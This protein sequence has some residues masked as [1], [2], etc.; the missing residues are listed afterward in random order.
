MGVAI[1]CG[2]K[3]FSCGYKRWNDFRIGVIQATIQYIETVLKPTEQINENKC[4]LNQ[5]L[6][7][8]ELV[9][10]EKADENF[11][12]FVFLMQTSK[13]QD[14][15]HIQDAFIHFGLGGLFV[16]CYKTDCDGYY[17][18]GNSVDIC[19]LFKKIHGCMDKFCPSWK[20][21]RSVFREGVKKRELVMV[22]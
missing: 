17:S 18:V 3:T 13:N 11:D 12:D 8:V 5:L 20:Q 4:F 16:L 7:F 21:V 2:E 9:H 22:I 14:H 19:D 6:E 1:V 10:L 15:V